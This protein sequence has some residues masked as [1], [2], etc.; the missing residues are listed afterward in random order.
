MSRYRLTFAWV[1]FIAG[2]GFI[3]IAG[4]LWQIGGHLHRKD[5]LST[6]SLRQ[7]EVQLKQTPGDEALR[8]TLRAEDV[9]LREQFFIR[10]RRI[11][12]GAALLL[13]SAI[14]FTV[15]AKLAW[16]VDR[17]KMQ[18]VAGQAES[19]W[20]VNQHS[21]WAVLGVGLPLVLAGVAVGWFMS[22]AGDSLPLEETITAEKTGQQVEPTEQV[23]QQSAIGAIDPAVMQN[24]PGFRGP[25]GQ[26][27]IT[28]RQAPVTWDAATKNNIRWRTAI[29]LP[30]HSSP[31]VWGDKIFITAADEQTQAVYCLAL[32]DGSIQW[33]YELDL[34]EMEEAEA[35]EVMEDTGYAAPTPATDGQRVYAIFAN[36]DLV[37]LDFAGKRLWYDRF[38]PVSNM[39]GHS[40]SLL[41][42]GQRVIVQF[43]Q[44][45]DLKPDLLTCYEGATGKI[46]WEKMRDIEGSWASPTLAQVN[47]R[48]MIVTT[49]NPSVIAYQ[50][51]TG[52]ELW[53]YDELAGDVAS[54]PIVAN[55]LT[56]AIEPDSEVVA[57]PAD[58][59]GKV[60]YEQAAWRSREMVPAYNCPVAD[61]EFLYVLTEM[62][63]FSSRRLSDGKLVWDKLVGKKSFRA[64]PVLVDGKLFLFNNAGEG[65]VFDPKDGKQ[66]G[67]GQVGEPVAAT[68]AFVGDCMI[69]RTEKSVVCIGEVKP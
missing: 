8:E 55:A 1:A 34:P 49:G 65:F 53:R 9:A 19:T 22:S 45:D 57:I 56:I 26:G 5:P 40:S 59:Q 27:R 43:D 50:A 64:S 25:M 31:I 29:D 20:R 3:V 36:G 10:Q 60:S 39:Y 42:F 18:P 58:K 15:T 2:L 6:Q 33:K 67:G 46:V 68:P 62:G 47:Q 17:M 69:V 32:S 63:D 4:A 28:G 12:W 51:D 24:W 66:I 7:M 23:N 37:A 11:D 38:G 21:R 35:L 54:S 48:M 16:P 61:D 41:C 52:E 14:V 13:G 44:T 30:G